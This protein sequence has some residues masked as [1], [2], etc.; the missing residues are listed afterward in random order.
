MR[1]IDEKLL[2]AC[3][4]GDLEKIKQ[5]L[6]NGADVNAKDKYGWT[7]LRYASSWGHKEIVELLKSYGAKE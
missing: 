2:N 6:E 1:D 3:E 4:V 5:L 7:A